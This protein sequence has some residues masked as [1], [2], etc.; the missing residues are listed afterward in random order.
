VTEQE[1]V[2]ELWKI[3]GQGNELEHEL[4]TANVAR[5]TAY[6]G[7]GLHATDIFEAILETARVAYFKP[8][9]GLMNPIGKRAL[10]NY[11]H[12]PLSTTISECGAWQVAKSIGPPWSELVATT[13]LRFLTLPDGSREVG[14]LTVYRPGKEKQRG[15][16]DAVPEQAAAGAFFDALIGQQDRN[17][18]NVLW[19]E[20][21]RVIY[22]IDHGFSF[23]RPGGESGDV[24]LTAWRRRQGPEDLLE[25]ELRALH[26]LLDNDL[27]DTRRF[28]EDDRADA[29]QE[30]VEDMA[31]R[32]KMPPVGRL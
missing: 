7:G 16:L 24:L 11:D 14:S 6:Q 10:K 4:A 1:Q 26:A 5:L 12:T 8:A 18:G 28:M 15:Y 13:A 31:A 2:N 27:F 32:R 19:Y 29:L 30:R 3:Q 17:D 25:P 9:N 23:G 21:R 22:L 20:E